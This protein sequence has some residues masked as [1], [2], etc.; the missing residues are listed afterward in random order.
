M[1]SD[2]PKSTKQFAT[3][4]SMIT[5]LHVQAVCSITFEIPRLF[6]VLV[7]SKL[8]PRLS[9]RAAGKITSLHGRHAG[10]CELKLR[11]RCWIQRV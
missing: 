5:S 9:C 1:Q 10:A 11:M 2:T 8:H 3:I 6:V 7:L 4:E